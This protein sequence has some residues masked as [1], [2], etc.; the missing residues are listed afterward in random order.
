MCMHNLYN[1]DERC[2]KKGYK[3]YWVVTNVDCVAV[4][5]KH[6]VNSLR[7]QPVFTR[8]FTR[9]YTSIPQVELVSTV[10]TAIREAF[11]WHSEK[12]KVPV[13]QLKV[14]V[15][16]PRVGHA[17]AQFADKGFLIQDIL[18]ILKAVCTEVYFQQGDRGPVLKQKQGLPMGRTGQ[19]VLLC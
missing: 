15:T 11:V 19:F 14:K 17:F 12:M 4:D 2:R 9:M 7:G 8:D 6:N 3:R 18:A 10:E 5:I 13:E 16:Y 1:K